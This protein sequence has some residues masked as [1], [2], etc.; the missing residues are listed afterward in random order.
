MQILQILLL[1]TV[2]VLIWVK[3]N[4]Q[5]ARLRAIKTTKKS[6]HYYVMT[7]NVT[8]GHVF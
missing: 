2:K 7:G 4:A 8:P 3:M 5:A 1:E 6:W